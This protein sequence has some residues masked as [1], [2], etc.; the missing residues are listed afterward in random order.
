M[1]KAYQIIE[2]TLL[3]DKGGQNAKQHLSKPVNSIPKRGF[4]SNRSFTNR[5]KQFIERKTNTARVRRLIR[6][7]RPIF[8]ILKTVRL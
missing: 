4:R 8:R 6:Q 2:N 5:A 7:R 3:C 1:T